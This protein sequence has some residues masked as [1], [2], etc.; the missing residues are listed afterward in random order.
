MKSFCRLI[1]RNIFTNL[2]HVINFATR[3]RNVQISRNIFQQ[4][5]SKNDSL[6]YFTPWSTNRHFL[7]FCLV[8]TKFTAFWLFEK[9][10]FSFSF[11]FLLFV[12]FDS[13]I[14][15]QCYRNRTYLWRNS[16]NLTG[17]LFTYLVTISTI[18][19][20]KINK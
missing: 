7:L 9:L 17:N 15:K 2:K 13:R 3:R 19:L 16:Q 8:E 4:I 11:S 18:I 14:Q 6:P 20:N 5:K 12:C 10:Y 1:W